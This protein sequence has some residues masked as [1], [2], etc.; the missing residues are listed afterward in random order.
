MRVL[1]PHQATLASRFG[2]ALESLETPIAPRIHDTLI[3]LRWRPEGRGHW[4]RTVMGGHYRTGTFRKC[5][6][7]IGRAARPQRLVWGGSM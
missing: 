4:T 6:W 2:N 5:R 1:A 3:G 7:E